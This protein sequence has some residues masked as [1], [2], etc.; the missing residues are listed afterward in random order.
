VS[1]YREG[2]I[3]AKAALHMMIRDFRF[4][5]SQTVEFA[6]NRRARGKQA[7]ADISRASFNHDDFLGNNFEFLERENMQTTT[8]QKVFCI[9]ALMLFIFV[10]SARSSVETTQM[11]KTKL[12]ALHVTCGTQKPCAVAPKPSKKRMVASW[13]GKQFQGRLT[14]SGELFDLNKLTAASKT[15]PI[16]TLVILMSPSNGRSI[17]VRIN[18]RGPY[19]R[20]R[21]LDLSEAAA[22]KLGIHEKGVSALEAA[23]FN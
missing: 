13:Y 7:R 20:G 4:G 14:S 22:I 10:T 5:V 11:P 18:D 9:A 12:P 8:G 6:I 16:G 2:A 17:V 1:T 19:V 15:L 21:D 3:A 23:V